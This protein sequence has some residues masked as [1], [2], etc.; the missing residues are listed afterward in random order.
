MKQGTMLTE[1]LM[2][3]E[4]ITVDLNT[5]SVFV[6]NIGSELESIFLGGRGLADWILYREIDRDTD[7]LGPNNVLVLSNG[8]L[9]GSAAPG[10]TRLQISGKSPQTGLIGFANIGGNFGAALQ[11]SGY[12]LVIVRSKARKPTCLY[13]RRGKVQFL[14]AEELWGLDTWNTEDRLHQE[15]G[16]P[17]EILSIGPAGENQV[18]F[19]S[20][21]HRHHYAAAR[22]G[23]G[24]LMGSKNLKAIL[25]ENVKDHEKPTAEA[26]AAAREYIGCVKASERY[27]RFSTYGVPECSSTSNKAGVLGVRN[28][29]DQQ[30]P[31]AEGISEE[32][33]YSYVSR[34]KSCYRCPVHC[35]ANIEVHRQN[36]ALYTGARP[37]WET[38]S[39]MGYKCGLFDA[40]QLIYLSD[41][42]N[43]MGIDT[44]ST[45][46]VLAF[47][48][49]LFSRD[50][51]SKADTGGIELSWGNFD[52]MQNIIKQIVNKEGFGRI[53][54]Q[55][56]KLAAQVIG[57]GAE[58][59]AF[60]VKG[61]EL[62]TSDPRSVKGLG[63][64]YALCSR[65]SDFNN[66]YTIP[67]SRWSGERGEEQ[68]GIAASV[69]QSTL[70]GKELLIKRTMAVC[71][72]IDCLGI[73]KIPALSLIMDF[74]LRKEAILA[75][76]ITGVGIGHE[77]L[78]KI[79]ERVLQLERL[80]NLKLGANSKDDYIP[81]M[82]HEVAVPSG[83][84]KGLKVDNFFKAVKRFYKAMGWD[85]E[86]I[87]KKETLYSC[88]LEQILNNT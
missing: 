60:H 54:S 58:Q 14:D 61:M 74:D 1:V 19:A 40:E 29:N 25:V 21:I 20:I 55:G 63:L 62:S 56:V 68:F 27:D 84:N 41:L 79:G 39:S 64:G 6:E 37:E 49:D 76:G 38:V 50:I 23:L 80:I 83:P 46:S 3:K 78:L 57:K 9:A 72:A 12:Q 31:N 16:E 66:V 86:G 65:G 77:D 67:E 18:A 45:G 24:A 85:N 44:M 35:K 2:Q 7:P 69:D 88:G 4:Q 8:L 26:A 75:S 82:F 70:E 30:D 17:I 51:I 33:L 10:S 81:K 73:C 43:K 5:K 47:S 71:A 32:K 15:I 52:A 22:S 13:I 11:H 59:F 53:L 34:F 28:F 36:G 87:P 48:M 42:C